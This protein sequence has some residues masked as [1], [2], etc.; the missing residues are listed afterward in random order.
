M[1]GQAI[2]SADADD[3]PSA[4]ELAAIELEWPLIAAELEVTGA[5][6]TLMTSENPTELDW[7]RLRRAQ[8]RRLRALAELLDLPAPG[9]PAPTAVEGRRHVVRAA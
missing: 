3:G 7:R 9:H 5:E 8:R 6:I 1:P 2:A 4:A